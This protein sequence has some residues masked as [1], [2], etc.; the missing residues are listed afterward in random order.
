MIS[1]LLYC[2]ADAHS[3]CARRSLWYRCKDV[4][5]PRCS[6]QQMTNT[7]SPSLL[8]CI[9]GPQHFCVCSLLPICVYASSAT[10]CHKNNNTL[11]HMSQKSSRAHI[12]GWM[13]AMPWR[14]RLFVAP[15]VPR[16]YTRVQYA[17]FQLRPTTW[18]KSGVPILSQHQ[19]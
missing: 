7:F 19:I 14:G 3:L 12:D 6:S 5:F 18:S 8:R 1:P 9:H 11:M 16:S 4:Y 17:I 10:M 13:G 2:A 15:Y